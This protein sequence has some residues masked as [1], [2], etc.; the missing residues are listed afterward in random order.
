VRWDKDGHDNALPDTARLACEDC[1]VI[2]S[3]R[4]RIGAL[5]ALEDALG[6][7]WRQTKEFMCCDEQQIPEQWDHAGRARCY[8][9]GQ[10]APYGGHAG[11]HV[12]KLY[13]KRHRLP[14]LVTEFLEAAGDP[15]L[16]RKFTNTALA[17]LWKPTYGDALDGSSLIV[18]AETYGP[19]DLPEEVLVV[20]G[21]CDVQGDRLEVQLIGWGRDEEAWPFQ[22]TV[23]NQDPSQP[24]AWAELNSLLMS[25]FKT[26]SGRILR[27]AAF[28]IDTG[29]H[30]GSQ[31]YAFAKA[32]R[33][34]RIFACKGIAGKRPIWSGHA[35]RSKMNDPLWLIGVDS[36]KD[37]IYGRLKIAPPEAG[38]RK[39]GF[40]HFPANE[41][42]GPDYFEQLTSEVRV[43]RKRMGQPYTVWDLP[44]G[45]RNEALDT[46]VG[47][48]AVRRSL[49]RRIEIGLQYSV[50]SERPPREVEGQRDS[51]APTGSS[52]APLA[53]PSVARTQEQTRRRSFADMLPK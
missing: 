3:E 28:G 42:F 14:E 7:G 48:L 17:E 50:V 2:W 31:V 53:G 34:R 20:T 22:Y 9:C 44:D 25:K 52:P 18:R 33:G 5:D 39:P 46:F 8:R 41:N 6:R 30:H 23:I 1:G 10:R 49:P 51:L 37:A 26:K 47:A 32:R 4:E 38:L 40:I 19:D 43:T 24:M 21:F 16:L 36:A 35:T 27:I 12:S 45:K 29:G 13:S 11:F 15:E